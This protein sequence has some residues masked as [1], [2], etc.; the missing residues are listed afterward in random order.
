MIP[1]SI[2]NAENHEW[3]DCLWEVDD[4][5]LLEDEEVDEIHSNIKERIDEARHG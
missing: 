4:I 3:C 5:I 2:C 1:C